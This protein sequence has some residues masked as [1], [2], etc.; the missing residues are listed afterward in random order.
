MTS[1]T[2]TSLDAAV[3]AHQESSRQLRAAM[4]AA[5]AAG[6]GRNEIARRTSGI[7][8]RA[9]VLGMLDR[10][11]LMARATTA[12][13]AA[14]WGEDDYRLETGRGGSVTITLALGWDDVPTETARLNAA[15]SAA[16]ALAQAGIQLIDDDR[17]FDVWELLAEIDRAVQIT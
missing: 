4:R 11:D 6:D 16:T 12:L 5:D 3:A 1:P 10:E 14:H 17:A 15:S 7:Y 13:Q 2:L 9:T 8:S